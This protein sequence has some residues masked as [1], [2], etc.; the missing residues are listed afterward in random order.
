VIVVA[1]RRLDRVLIHMMNKKHHAKCKALDQAVSQARSQDVMHD[2]CKSSASK[3]KWDVV[4]RK[5]H[6]FN[7]NIRVSVMLHAQVPKKW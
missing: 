7:M 4:I 2:Q 5:C 6:D 3:L 1:R